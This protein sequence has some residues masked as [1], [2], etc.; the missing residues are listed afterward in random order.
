MTF[1]H[2][3]AI[4]NP[5]ELEER[6]NQAIA[7]LVQ[8]TNFTTNDFGGELVHS[9]WEPNEYSDDY[10]INLNTYLDFG[11]PNTADYRSMTTDYQ[12]FL[13]FVD[14][15]K[16]AQFLDTTFLQT[17]K[18]TLVAVDFVDS[19]KGPEIIRQ[20][21][22][23]TRLEMEES[24]R[25]KWVELLEELR[26]L[27]T[28]LTLKRSPNANWQDAV[29]WADLF[30]DAHKCFKRI[31]SLAGVPEIPVDDRSFQIPSE[32]YFKVLLN[33]DSRDMICSLVSGLTVYRFM[34]QFEGIYGFQPYSGPIDESAAQVDEYLYSLFIEIQHESPIEL[35]VVKRIAQAYLVE[36]SQAVGLDL[37]ILTLSDFSDVDILEKLDPVTKSHPMAPLAIS[38]DLGEILNLYYQAN[39]VPDAEVR[40]L[41]FRGTTNL[42]VKIGHKEC[43]KMVEKLIFSSIREQEFCKE[44][45]FSE[46]F[47][48]IITRASFFMIILSQYPIFPQSQEQ[49]DTED[50][51]ADSNTK[52]TTDN[53][54]Y[55]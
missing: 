29:E 18:R 41:L 53:L 42:R 17:A 20:I 50:F 55:H 23:D 46:F 48:N 52:K 34:M 27:R 15:L 1:K 40:I 8:K 47:D 12:G 43:Q 32:S 13:A 14:E 25:D 16:T 31:E 39:I 36:L 22:S 7:F 51:V 35:E 3:N 33:V 49:F 45:G 37:R 4:Y 10:E 2:Q 19:I 6:I 28:N 54:I 11:L 9:V 26:E 21:P 30:D 24:L 44:I 38:K 5:P